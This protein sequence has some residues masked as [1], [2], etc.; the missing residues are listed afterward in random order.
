MSPLSL[1]PESTPTTKPKAP[2]P[3][4]PPLVSQSPPAIKP[5][6]PRPQISKLDKDSSNSQV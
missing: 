6:P 3:Q 1:K 2:A 4:V 5:P